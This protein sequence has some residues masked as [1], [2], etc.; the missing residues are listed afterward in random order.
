MVNTDVQSH[1][2]FKYDIHFTE[3]KKRLIIN[4]TFVFSDIC[5]VTHYCKNSVA[6]RHTMTTSGFSIVTPD[7]VGD[8]FA[9]K[10]IPLVSYY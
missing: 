7:Q 9:T 4:A 5:H 3:A 8:V 6:L 1:S 2:E 10:T